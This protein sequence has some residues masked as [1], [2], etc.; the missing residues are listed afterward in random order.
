MRKTNKLRDH[1]NDYK[2]NAGILNY[3]KVTN[4]YYINIIKNNIK[5]YGKHSSIS[6]M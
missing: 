3:R 1:E 2:K 5:R 6:N 4:I